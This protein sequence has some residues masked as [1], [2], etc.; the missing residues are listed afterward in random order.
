MTMTET[1]ELRR[2]RA[3]VARFK[4]RGL[5]LLMDDCIPTLRGLHY[6]GM[7]TPDGYLLWL[8]AE[9]VLSMDQVDQLRRRVAQL[10]PKPEV[11][12]CRR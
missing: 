7:L 12:T 1:E 10:E 9:R 2:K 4:K 3:L 6:R 11:V 8:Q 5:R